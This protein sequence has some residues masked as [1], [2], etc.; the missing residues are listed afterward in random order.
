ME[1]QF[2]ANHVEGLTCIGQVLKS[3]SKAI[4]ETLNITPETMT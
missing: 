1:V 4:W 3:I 2:M